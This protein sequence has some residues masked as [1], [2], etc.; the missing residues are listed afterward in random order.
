MAETIVSI[1]ET[2]FSSRVFTHDYPKSLKIEAHYQSNGQLF[3]SYYNIISL[4][5][6][7]S[8][9]KLTQKSKNNA[10]QYPIPDNYIVETEIFER[11]LNC[12]TKYISNSKLN[13]N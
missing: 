6:Y 1:T 5:T 13:Y 3:I 10:I 12:K 8:T 2:T 7:P 11:S 9:P 4:G